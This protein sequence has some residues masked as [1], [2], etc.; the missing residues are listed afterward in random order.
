M[1]HYAPIFEEIVDSSVW[2]E[3][4][5]VVKVFLTMLAKKRQDGV[6]YGTAFNIAQWAKKSEAEVLDALRILSAP[7]KRRLEPQPFE[8]RRIEKVEG[9][10]L[11]LNAQK[12]QKRMME[13]NKRHSHAEAQARLRAKQKE[14]EQRSTWNHECYHADS[15]TVLH[16]LNEKSG[17][18]YREVDTNLKFISARLMEP[19]VTLDGVKLMIE[20]QCRRWKGTAQADYLRPETLFNKTKFDGYYAAKEQPIYDETS[21]P[22]PRNFGI[23]ISPEE[24]TKQVLAK[25]QREE[26]KRA[27]ERDARRTTDLQHENGMAKQ[28]AQ[29]D[30]LPSSS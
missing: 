25:Q 15:R 1:G 18:H 22:N 7:D 20:R 13:M 5:L 30:E 2:C 17:R 16:W 4:D 24:Q 23:N 26:A 12:Y 3:S 6:V 14:G 29:T 9:G 21:K 10:W 11:M 28:V 8:G 27:A 19:D